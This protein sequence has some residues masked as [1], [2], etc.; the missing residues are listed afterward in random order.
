[1]LLRRKSPEKPESQYESNGENGELEEKEDKKSGLREKAKNIWAKLGLDAGTF[2]MMMKGAIPPT[3]SVAIYQSNSVADTYTTLGYLIAIVSIMGFCIL[4]RAKFIQM[5][6][7]NTLAVCVGT[8]AAL[9]MIYSA[10]KARQ[11]SEPKTSASSVGSPAPGAPTVEYNS[12]ASAVCGVWLFF[13]I[14]LVN[15]VRA[16]FP[17]FNMSVIIYSIFANISAIYAP[18]FST[19]TAGIAFAKRLLE[20]FLTGLAISA[21]TSFIILPMTSRKVVFK[22]MAGYIGSLR[23]ALKAHAAYFESMEHTDMFG[24]VETFDKKSE[25]RLKKGQKAYSP[26]ADA[27][28]TA[29]RGIL[30]IHGKLHGD[31]TF[32]KREV[33]LGHLGPDDLQEIF[34]HLRRTMIPVVG[35]SSIVDVFERLSEYNKWNDPLDDAPEDI[36]SDPVRQRVVHEWNDMMTAVHDPFSSMLEIIDEGLQHVSYALRITKPPKQAASK[37]SKDT[38]PNAADDVE[39]SPAKASPGESGFA[40]YLEKKQQEFRSAK[41]LAVRAWCEEKGIKLPSNFF[42]HPEAVEIQDELTGSLS[43]NHV[44]NQRQL[45]LLLYMA[46]LLYSI[47]Q[48][49]LDFVH[50]ADGRVASGK[51][52]QRRL[53]IPGS[54]R[55][56]K[57]LIGA[58]KGEDGHEDHPLSEGFSPNRKLSLGEAFNKRKDPE[59][60]P[61]ETTWQIIGDKIRLIPALL[62]S[63]QSAFGFRVACAIMTIAVIAFLHST[64]V[65]FV[66]QRL[67]W[68]MIMVA[69]SMSP[70]TG[71]SIFGF[72]LRLVGTT[73]AMVASFLIWYIPGQKTPGIIVFLFVFATLGFYIPI[74]KPRFIIVGFISIVTTTMITGYELEVRQLGEAVATSN[75]QV[76]YPTYLLAPYR[77]AVVAAGLLVAFIW[78]IF[79]YPISEHSALRQDLGNSL[80]LLANY[81][82]LIH[83][84]V[85]ARIRGDSEDLLSTTS[86]GRK[87]EK[88]RNRVFS[89]QMLMLAGLRTHC[90]FLRWE[91]PIG[92]KFPKQ[93][94]DIIINCMQNIVNY[95]SLVA[96]A[97]DTFTRIGED[98]EASQNAWFNDFKRLMAS[99]NLTSHEITSL[100]ALLAASITNRQP[101]PPYLRTPTP[102]GFSK[103]LEALDRDILSLRHSAEPGYAAFAVLQIST[104]CIIGDLDKLL[105]NVKALVGEL[106]FSFHIVNTASNSNA[107]LVDPHSTTDTGD[108]LSDPDKND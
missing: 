104:R 31:L 15:T 14:Y 30:E 58:F 5:L 81:Y 45:Y 23:G 66:K 32:A 86:S 99:A 6:I 11:H 16:K 77:L 68:A 102:Y 50:F 63:P 107:N 34:R 43:S 65:F 106:D 67:V 59:H 36:H 108:P 22:Q 44:R 28:K 87:L 10:V 95:V 54:K 42:E 57:W 51:M 105:K 83:E 7:F 60:L 20:A 18:Q 49:V 75:G 27:I 100:L 9:L 89:K 82:S 2:M 74:K 25:K 46:H 72:V 48:A 88:A 33:A 35:L 24:R 3:V 64:Q 101:L 73:L 78:T 69:I 62:R 103:R 53:I 94:Y 1:M 8:A 85:S 21:A 70:T 52:S 12:S 41:L 71:Q 90:E 19:M 76:Y 84:T 55:L 38:G 92:G 26:E 93:H 29:V 96:Y 97:S 17:Q 79:P 4:P 39:A 91:V 61:P 40:Q 80:Y 56:K 37:N 47:N 13:Q 98:A